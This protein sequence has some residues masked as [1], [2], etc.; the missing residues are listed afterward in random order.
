[1]THPAESRYSTMGR[2]SATSVGNILLHSRMRSSSNPNIPS[3][4]T[5]AE[6]FEVNSIMSFKVQ[7]ISPTQ[8][9]SKTRSNTCA[10]QYVNTPACCLSPHYIKYCNRPLDTLTNECINHVQCDGMRASVSRATIFQAAV[11]PPMWM[12]AATHTRQAAPGPPT[13][14]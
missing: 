14:R 4:Q 6:D 5:S 12:Q 10:G 9:S 13:A 7:K 8:I 1:M 2:A 11:C 3:S